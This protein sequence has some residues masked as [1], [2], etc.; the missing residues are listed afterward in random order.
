MRSLAQPL[1]Y[2]ST[3]GP[4]VREAIAEFLFTRSR[5]DAIAIVTCRPEL[6]RT[7]ADE[8]ATRSFSLY[9]ASH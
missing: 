1:S 5:A 7:Q 4:G 8:D 3:L 6:G 9:R 2:G